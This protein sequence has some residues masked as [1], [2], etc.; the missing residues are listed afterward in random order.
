VVEPN[1]KLAER[2]V[3]RGRGVLVQSDEGSVADQVHG[4]VEVAD[5]VLIDHGLGVE[6]RR[7]PRHADREVADRECHVGEGW[8]CSHGSL[9]F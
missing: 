6:E 5:G 2:L 1:S 7:V 4:V 3:R 8:E 9:P